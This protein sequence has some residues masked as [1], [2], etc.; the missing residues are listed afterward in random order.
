MSQE[1]P[2]EDGLY[3]WKL[4]IGAQGARGTVWHDVIWSD[5]KH[6]GMVHRGPSAWDSRRAHGHIRMWHLADIDARN[7]GNLN[8][9]RRGRARR[10]TLYRTLTRIVIRGSKTSSGRPSLRVFY[11]EVLCLLYQGFP[12][13]SILSQQSL[14][15]TLMED[16]GLM[17]S[18]WRMGWTQYTL[19]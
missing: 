6:V 18:Q 17:P 8:T 14:S 2:G 3:H 5:K 4:V 16:S 1:E 13:T 11:R 10:S 19:A 7:I 12:N 15:V 9:S